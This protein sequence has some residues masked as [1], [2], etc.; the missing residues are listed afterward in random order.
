M[1]PTPDGRD[2]GPRH[3]VAVVGGGVAGLATALDLTL[4]N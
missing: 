2:G 1:H 3:E 4:D